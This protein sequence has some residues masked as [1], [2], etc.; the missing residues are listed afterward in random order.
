M[1]KNFHLWLDQP[2]YISGVQT[3][4]RN[5]IPCFADYITNFVMTLGYNFIPK[6]KKG[7]LCVARW[8]YKM[9]IRCIKH[10]ITPF[11]YD[12]IPHRDWDL[13]Y[14]NY[15]DVFDYDTITSI[16]NAWKHVDD[17]NI[18]TDLG[19]DVMNELRNFIWHY[20]DLET[21]PQ[22]RLIANL[23]E[24]SDSETDEHGEKLDRYI[25]DMGEGYHG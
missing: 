16:E 21:S 17:L 24:G 3:A 25:Q 15:Y 1:S 6:W 12:D 14:Y 8:L 9:N 11:P 2:V 22:G 23:V 19:S 18:E 20:I 5:Y 13:D 7:H 10:I 4:R